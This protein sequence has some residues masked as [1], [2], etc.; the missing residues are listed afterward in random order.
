MKIQHTLPDGYSELLSVDLKSNKKLFF[1]VNAAAILIGLALV[2]PM[3]F[4]VPFSALFDFSEGLG[5]Y[6][7]RFGVLIVGLFAYIVLHELIHGITMKCFGTKKVQYGFSATYAFA[8]S[9]DYYAKIPYLVIA[10]APVAVFFV[11]FAILCPLLPPSWFWVVYL[12]Q[13]S[14]LSGAAGDFYVT[15]KFFK[16]PKDILVRDSG[17]SMTVYAKADKE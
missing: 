13:V 16:L 9:D 10:L 11:I 7:L 3:L 6:C 15:L 4:F 8:G 14:N 17:V 5:M 12:L 2:V 1:G